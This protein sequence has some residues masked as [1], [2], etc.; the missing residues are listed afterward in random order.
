[1]V[2]HCPGTS[3][4]GSSDQ[5]EMGVEQHVTGPECLV[6]RSDDHVYAAG[7]YSGTARNLLV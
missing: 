6:G 1:M 5:Q 7:G 2:E 4:V 3:D